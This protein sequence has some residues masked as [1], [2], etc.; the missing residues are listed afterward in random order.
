MPR[1]FEPSSFHSYV[2]PQNTS[3]YILLVKGRR[4]SLRS[5]PLGKQQP[6]SY[7]LL[8]RGAKPSYASRL[9]NQISTFS[10]NAN[11]T[12]RL[13]KFRNR[14]HFSSDAKRT[15]EKTSIHRCIS[16][17]WHIISSIVPE[18]ELSESAVEDEHS[19]NAST[20]S[21][22][23]HCS[24][25]NGVNVNPSVKN[26]LERSVDGDNQDSYL[27]VVRGVEPEHV[28][29]LLV[30]WYNTFAS[31]TRYAEFKP[32]HGHWICTADELY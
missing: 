7:K 2:N 28:R 8:N 25:E 6:N 12:K 23:E 14:S 3:C 18:Y 24:N 10:L 11:A 5:C 13:H 21:G 32:R 22:Q 1:A 19:T 16:S 29:A 27:V 31:Y 20:I 30:M 15:Y 26:C 17:D 4:P 9:Q